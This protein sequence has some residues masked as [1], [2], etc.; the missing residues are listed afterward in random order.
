M[1]RDR[2]SNNLKSYIVKSIRYYNDADL[3]R[4]HD[5]VV[6][7]C[8]DKMKNNYKLKQSIMQIRRNNKKTA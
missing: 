2:I 8:A 5:V 4:L 1:N 3:L 6:N 7:D